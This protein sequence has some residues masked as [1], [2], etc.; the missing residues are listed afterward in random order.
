MAE[1]G[2]WHPRFGGG[3][4][5]S[6]AVHI[7]SAL[8]PDHR[9]SLLTLSDVDLRAELDHYGV[10]LADTVSVRT[11]ASGTI[12]R[13]AA[14]LLERTVGRELW[15][16][17]SALFARA[18]RRVT[19]EFDLVWSTHGEF[20]TETPSVQYVHYPWYGR[21]KIPEPIESHSTAGIAYERMCELLAGID[22]E[23]I[24][25]KRLLTNSAW[26]ADVVRGV[27]GTTPEVLPP[28]VETDE[29]DPLP[30]DERENGFVCL[31]RFRRDKN[32]LR[33]V[34]IVES[35]RKRGHDVHL[36]VVGPIED[37]DYR[38]EVRTAAE[39][40]R[41]H[42]EGR[43]PRDELVDL[44]CSHK[45]GIHGK[46]REHFGIAVAEMVAGGAIPFA[47]ANGGPVDILNERS[48][49]LYE[50]EPDAVSKA[51]T[52]IAEPRL[53][54]ELRGSLPDI[55]S[56]YDPESFRRRVREITAST[57]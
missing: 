16:V 26:T 9:V 30:W 34:R 43:I 31:G 38:D 6:V 49:L 21:T 5:E 50:S 3:G 53:Q 23:N 20:V 29:F 48:T 52:V 19:S 33:N 27:Y 47:P 14:E 35:L 4:A 39:S 2:V 7:I 45:Y 1:I 24:A 28:P 18:A 8:V 13:N 57:L 54:A 32:V 55:G 41:I 40:D 56:E 42:I 37:T 11:T 15:R 46:E 22:R 51:A 10:E 36:H 12:V 25:S 17:Q 44:L